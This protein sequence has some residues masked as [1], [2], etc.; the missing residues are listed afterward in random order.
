MTLSKTRALRVF[1]FLLKQ[2][3]L[4]LETGKNEHLLP[5]NMFPVFD[6]KPH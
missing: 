1:T 5:N 3:L 6:I 4:N 2:A